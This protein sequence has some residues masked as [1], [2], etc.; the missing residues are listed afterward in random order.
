MMTKYVSP[1]T[2]SEYKVVAT[3]GDSIV[4]FRKI[5]DSMFRVRIQNEN[6]VKLGEMRAA[7]HKDWGSVKDGDHISCVVEE[8]ALINAILDAMSGTLLTDATW[9]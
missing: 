1:Q 2:G 3:V 4:C 9:K 6:A 5:S 7:M 8:G